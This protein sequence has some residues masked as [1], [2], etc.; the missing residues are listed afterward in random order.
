MTPL[1]Q[2]MRVSFMQCSSN[3]ENNIVDHVGVS[4]VVEELGKLAASIRAYVIELVDQTLRGLFGDCRCAD[5]RC[6]VCE[7]VPIVCRCQLEL[8]VCEWA[9]VGCSR[10]CTGH[11][12][13]KGLAL[14]QIAV[15]A[16]SEQ[17]SFIASVYVS[18]M[19][20]QA[21]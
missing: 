17:A 2:F 15:M 12:T 1:E 14:G 16:L 7:K 21:V 3:E 18:G 20:V 5:G 10:R 4:D 8:E 9:L 13:I 11:R 19:A 6:F